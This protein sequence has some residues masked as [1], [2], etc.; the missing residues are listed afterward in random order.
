LTGVAVPKYYNPAA[1]N[2]LKFAE[3]VKK[4]KLLWSKKDSKAVSLFIIILLCIIVVYTLDQIYYQLL[5]ILWI[6]YTINYCVYFGSDILSIIVYTLDQ[7]YYQLLCINYPDFNFFQE[8]EAAA[9]AHQAALAK[10]AEE[11]QQSGSKS[12]SS[13][14]KSTAFLED[15]DGRMAAKFRKLMGIKDAESSGTNP[16]EGTEETIKKQQELFNQLDREY[17]FARMTTHTHRGIGLGF[18]SQMYP[19]LK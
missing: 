4:R 7:I 5:C 16:D 13:Q 2:P 17:Q 1:V 11:G 15:K 19:D 14:W 3:Q 12:G 10:A 6:R 8:A 18:T 9:A